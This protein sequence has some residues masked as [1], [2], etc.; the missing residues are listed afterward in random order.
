MSFIIPENERDPYYKKLRAITI[1]TIS[2]MA[3]RN[4]YFARNLVSSLSELLSKS[5]DPVILN[6]VIVAIADIGERY[7][8]IIL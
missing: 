4:D 6:N 2:K 5:N 3:L 1:I 8:A 7:G